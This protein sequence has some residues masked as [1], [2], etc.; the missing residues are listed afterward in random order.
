MTVNLNANQVWLYFLRLL[1]LAGV[2]LAAIPSDSIPTSLKPWFAIGGAIIL[3]VDR[4]VADPSTGNTTTPRRRATTRRFLT[5]V[6]RRL[7]GNSFLDNRGRRCARRRVPA[8]LPRDRS[9]A[10]GT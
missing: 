5:C 10:G 8:N 7:V 2:A 3:A 1:S 6:C 4:Y 9:L